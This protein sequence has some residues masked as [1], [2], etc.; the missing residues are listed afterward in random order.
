[1]KHLSISFTNLIGTSSVQG[2]FKDPRHFQILFQAAFLILGIFML[3]WNLDISN[4]IL[5]I[6]TCLLVQGLG[7]YISGENYSGLKSSLISALSICLMLK[8]NEPSTFILAAVLSI[9]SKYL[10]KYK[11]KHI[12]NPTNFGMILCILISG[13]AWF[14]PGQWGSDM[15]FLFVLMLSASVVLLKVGRMDVA[16]AFLLTFSGLYFLKIVVFLGWEIDVFIHHLSSGTLLLFTFF[17]ITDPVTSPKSK[18]G[19]IVWAMLI[20]VLAFGI[21]NWYYVHSA[22]IWALFILSPVSVLLNKYYK[23]ETF[24]WIIT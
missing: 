23:G 4:F 24:K 3:N 1:M 17:M 13:D 9:A 18:K 12:F 2:L 10:I 7:I 21:S 11:G 22:P 16:L 15:L 5:V 14:S 20:G 19:R 6:F 8:A